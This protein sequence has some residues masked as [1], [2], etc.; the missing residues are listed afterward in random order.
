LFLEIVL[1]SSKEEP[2][3][4]TEIS[5]SA[6]STRK[7]HHKKTVVSTKPST[8]T[9]YLQTAST[10]IKITNKIANLSETFSVKP[11]T[12]PMTGSRQTISKENPDKLIATYAKTTTNN[13]TSS[14]STTTKMTT[15]KAI[16][17][18]STSSKASTTPNI[19][20]T[21]Y[22]A[23]TT[24]AKLELSSPFSVID[25]NGYMTDDM[26][27]AQK[28]NQPIFVETSTKIIEAN[29]ATTTK[30]FLNIYFQ[31]E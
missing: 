4:L 5:P 6:L 17:R 23:S 26:N 9:K 19:K 16:V 27:G 22:I 1:T 7:P 30:G 28:V 20:L 18:N 24:E 29:D 3:V 14:I 25:L 11:K 15:T 2:S 12:N 10:T 13:L 8:T 31:R 21:H